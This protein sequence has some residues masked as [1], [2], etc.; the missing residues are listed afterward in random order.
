MKYAQS[1][2]STLLCG[3]LLCMAMLTS[4]SL[5][6]QAADTPAQ[7]QAGLQQTQLTL[8]QAID[9]AEAAVPGRSIDAQLDTDKGMPRFEIK[10]ITPQNKQV[11]VHVN[12]STGAAL[13]HKDKGAAAAKDKKQLEASKIT[14]QQAIAAAL[15]HTPGTAV[16]AELSQDWGRTV[17]AVDVLTAAGQ[18][19]EIKLNPENASVLSSK[20]D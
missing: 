6:V 5:P 2:T 10:L 7:L 20:V 1:T 19:L 11:E 16:D 8:S 15:K 4:A 12:A 9:A 17:I 13:Q 14:L 18:R 3:S